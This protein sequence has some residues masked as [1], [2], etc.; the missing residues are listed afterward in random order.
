MYYNKKNVNDI[1]YSNNP[2]T[3]YV[4]NLND[5][6]ERWEQINKKFKDSDIQLERIPAIKHKKGHIGCGLSFIKAVKFA[7]QNNME[8]ILIF[9]DDNKPLPEFNKRWVIIKEWLDKNLDKWDIY[10]G[11]ARYPDWQEYEKKTTSSHSEKTVLKYS[12][13]EKEYLFQAPLVVSTNW[14]Y[15]N[16][17]AYDKIIKWESM[18]HNTPL[19]PIDQYI[20]DTNYFNTVFSIP[21]LALQEDGQSDTSLNSKNGYWEFDKVDKRLIA[22]FNE[23]YYK[24]LAKYNL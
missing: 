12:I 6:P 21:H 17:N 15:I 5:R 18:I 16:K 23:V 2:N 10:N 9:E 3:A 13:E 19:I 1:K 8:T 4:I 24:E 14:I 22:I 7:K 11:G 20:T